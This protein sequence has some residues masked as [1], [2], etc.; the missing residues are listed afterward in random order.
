[1]KSPEARDYRELYSETKKSFYPLRP[2]FI[3][4]SSRKKLRM[5]EVGGGRGREGREGVRRA[6]EEF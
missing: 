2:I 6:G 1:M 3:L 4:S 5:R